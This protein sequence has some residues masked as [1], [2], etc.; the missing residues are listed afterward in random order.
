MIPDDDI[1]YLPIRPDLSPR[2]SFTAPGGIT[3][4]EMIFLR[5]AKAEPLRIPWFIKGDGNHHGWFIM[6]D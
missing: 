5:R 6:D 2:R 1:N 3:A 4:T